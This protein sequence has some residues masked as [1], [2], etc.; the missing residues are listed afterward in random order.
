M[1]YLDDLCL[2][3]VPTS[4]DTRKEVRTKVQDRFQHSDLNSS[5]DDAFKIWDAVSGSN[6]HLL[7]NHKLTSCAAVSGGEGRRRPGERA[8]NV[9]RDQSLVVRKKVGHFYND[10][11]FVRDQGPWET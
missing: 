1:H 11:C 5:L 4:K 9:G 10:Q 7:A 8:E 3:S 2:Y 6:Q